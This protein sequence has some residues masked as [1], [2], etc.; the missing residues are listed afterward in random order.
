[1]LF[2]SPTIRNRLGQILRTVRADSDP[3]FTANRTIGGT[4]RNN[5]E[6]QRY[7]SSLPISDNITFTHSPPY[8]QALN[9]VE[10]AAR[11]LY[12]LMNYYL[13]CG[14]LS[15]LSWVDMLQAAAYSMNHLPHPQSRD[16]TRRVQSA[17]EIMTG[18]KPDLS[19]MIAGPG[20]LVIVDLPGAKASG[21][22]PTGTHCIFIHPTE[23]GYLVRRCHD[24]TLHTSRLVRKLTG[25]NGYTGQIVS[26]STACNRE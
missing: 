18:R 3:C 8:T 6:L 19:K 22:A 10:C 17:E 15:V 12:H 4:V 16:R 1:M 24:K 9:P 2:R 21:G 13:Q 20:E 26:L 7:L 23:G 5:P 11:Q 25:P 14:N